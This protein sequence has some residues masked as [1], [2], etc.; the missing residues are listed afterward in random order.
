MEIQNFNSSLFVSLHSIQT[1]YG[2][3]P[4]PYSSITGGFSFLGIKRQRR[5]ADCFT[6]SSVEVKMRGVIPPLLL[7]VLN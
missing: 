2:A 6:P 7:V 4:F 5:A 1:G 3:H